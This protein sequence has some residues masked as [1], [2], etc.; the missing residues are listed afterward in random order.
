MLIQIGEGDFH[1]FIMKT[2]ENKSNKVQT[3]VSDYH[4]FVIEGL[5]G[6][7]GVSKS[8]VLSHIIRSWIDNNINLLNSAGLTIKDWKGRE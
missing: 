3:S 2:D 1:L 5:V 7:E 6:I 8:D 4:L